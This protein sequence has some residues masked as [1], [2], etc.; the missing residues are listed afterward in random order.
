[1][2][3]YFTLRKANGTVGALRAHRRRPA[4]R[5]LDTAS[6]PH[7]RPLLPPIL[8]SVVA[9]VLSTSSLDA[10]HAHAS[11]SRPDTTAHATTDTGSM[12]GMAGGDMRMADPIGLPMTRTGSGTTWL[13][14]SAPMYARMTSAGGWDLM[15]HGIAFVQYDAQRTRRGDSQ[16]G[17]VNWGM[18]MASHSLGAGRLSL[19]GMVSL[20]P[21]TVSARGYPLL[22][23]SG[24]SFGGQPLHDRQHPHDLFMEIAGIYELPITRAIGA[25]LYV[26]PVGEPAVGPVAFPHRPS[27]AS[28]PMAPIGHH[29]QDATHISFGVLT[30]ALYT[31]AVKLEGSVFNGREPDEIRT[32]FDYR[33]RSLDSYAGR[34][35]VN[36][37]PQLS[38]SGAYA[39]LRSPEE[40]EPDLALHRVTASALYGYRL[41]NEGQ[42]SSALVYGGNRHAGEGRFS[43]SLL[44]EVNADLDGRNTFFGRAEYVQKSTTDLAVDD[45]GGELV[46]PLVMPRRSAF[47]PIRSRGVGPQSAGADFKLGSFTLGYVRQIGK[48]GGGSFGV[49]VLGTL[50]LVPRSLESAYGTRVPKGT[51]VYVRIR[52]T[53]MDMHMGAHGSAGGMSGGMQ[54]GGAKTPGSPMDTHGAQPMN[55]PQMPMTPA[56][57]DSTMAGAAMANSTLGTHGDMHAGM[58]MAPGMAMPASDSAHQ[59]DSSMHAAMT[60]ATADRAELRRRLL[61]DPVIGRRIAADSALRRLLDATAADMAG[62]RDSTAATVTPATKRPAAAKKPV[63][64][65]PKKAPARTPART[66]AKPRDPMA[67]MQMPGMSHP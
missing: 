52:P 60:R 26:A 48:F 13:P 45:A 32:N 51:A 33:G 59:M 49:G 57:R 53:R 10:Q 5:R 67:G 64:R 22:L 44:G 61:A 2:A 12:A 4:P 15:L 63:A 43:H 55:M 11:T 14:D 19:R 9:L 30:G 23:Q 21:W 17:S 40:L 66:P 28:N 25:Q 24:E 38:L 65:T 47:G 39:Y 56:P 3:G 36:A 20:E 37:T 1:V 31:H 16:F 34:L 35:T 27:A 42:L 46:S 54:M 29:W 62:M 7:M 18:A 6:T 50:G 8:T 41:G 58:A